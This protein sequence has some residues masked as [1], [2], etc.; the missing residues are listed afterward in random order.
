MMQWVIRS[1]SIIL[2]SSSMR[3]GLSGSVGKFLPRFSHLLL[4]L[5]LFQL[6]SVQ[7]HHFC[8]DPGV[9]WHLATGQWIAQ[10]SIVPRVDPHLYSALPRAWVADQ[11]L[12]DLILYI[13]Y[14]LLGWAGL[15]GLVTSL[16]IVAFL[17]LGFVKTARD[18][19]LVLVTACLALLL[20]KIAEVHFI[21]R[22]VVFGFLCFAAVYQICMATFVGR[23]NFT[24]RELYLLSAI[25]ILWPNL[26]GSFVLGL[27]LL[28][29][30]ALFG[31]GFSQRW[32]V[33]LGMG[34]L[35]LLN[36]YGWEL[37]KSIIQLG[38]SSYFM[39][40]HQEWLPVDFRHIEGHIFEALLLGSLAIALLGVTLRFTVFEVVTL[41]TFIHLSLNS[42]RFLPF[43][44]IIALPILVR[45]AE[46]LISKLEQFELGARLVSSWWK[47]E[48]FERSGMVFPVRSIL[49]LFMTA[50]IWCNQVP[51]YSGKLGIDD[52]K[53][54][55]KAVE[56]LIRYRGGAQTVVAA[57]PA[58]GGA[59]TWYGQGKVR[60]IIDDRNT[61]LGEAEYRQFDSEFHVL[62]D[63]E[64]FA[65]ARGAQFV[66]VPTQS[67]F[68]RALRSFKKR[69][70]LYEDGTA[71]IYRV[72][73]NNSSF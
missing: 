49:L 17:G 4:A 48:E 10:H 6:L 11:W 18:S 69:R 2:S 43:F 5:L 23:R 27:L 7:L 22:P 47:L 70:P 25:F 8:D 14:D 33:L 42:V 24:K 60:A 52:S 1:L 54:P 29:L 73:R 28:L 62:G 32:K 41:V 67:K 38:G 46:Q 68:S 61:L 16:F 30:F 50:T 44:A 35:T 55:I 51:F 12:S 63:W 57:D 56:Y 37:H 40:L 65:R 34:L 3:G 13:T 64:G 26:H 66:I 71:A 31:G 19:G 36:P 15:Y 39:A 53:F 21:L 45:L 58:W 72:R 20:T 9:G 59:I